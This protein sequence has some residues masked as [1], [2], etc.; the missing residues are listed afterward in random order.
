MG[1]ISFPTNDPFWVLKYI[2]PWGFCIRDCQFELG[3]GHRKNNTGGVMEQRSTFFSHPG[4]LCLQALITASLCSLPPLASVISVLCCWEQVCIFFSVVGFGMDP[5]LQMDIITEL[6]LVNTTLGVT[7]VSGLHNTSK[8][9]L[10][11]GKDT[12]SFGG[13]TWGGGPVWDLFLWCVFVWGSSLLFILCFYQEECSKMPREV[14]W[15]YEG[16]VGGIWWNS[17]LDSD[18]FPWE[19][20]GDLKW[21]EF[22]MSLK[23]IDQP[24]YFY[25][26]FFPLLPVSSF[27]PIPIPVLIPLSLFLI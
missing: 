17:W 2:W 6:D 1:H 11:Q 23:A 13:T 7:Q 8:A 4:K 12:F 10:F 15:G 25:R 20:W 18:V 22:V 26:I 9:F 24:S 14:F 21:N 16:E 3:Q 19:F 5:D 27:I